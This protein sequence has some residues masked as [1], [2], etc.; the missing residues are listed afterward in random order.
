MARPK[1]ITEKMLQKLEA[2]F[3]MDCTD[4][5]AC[6]SAG[7]SP[8]TLYNYQKQYP[9]FLEQKLRFKSRPIF[10]A[11][12]S[13]ING[14]INDPYLALKYL[15]RKRKDEFSIRAEVDNNINVRSVAAVLLDG[16]EY[17]PNVGRP[18]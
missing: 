12:K 14:I 15:E 8:S 16:K 11:R 6:F 9:E 5:E 10:L 17:V 2:A 1:V 4:E 13:L 7:I 3:L 18:I